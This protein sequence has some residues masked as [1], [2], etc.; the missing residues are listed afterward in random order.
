M[1][2]VANQ[3]AQQRAMGEAIYLI[4]VVINHT[5]GPANDISTYNNLGS[6]QIH[7]SQ[8]CF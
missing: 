8:I 5:F 1:V 3:A 4:V 2:S 6:K 7:H